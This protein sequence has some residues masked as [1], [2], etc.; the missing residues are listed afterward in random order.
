MGVAAARLVFLGF[1][2]LTGSIIY[3]ALYLQNLH[4]GAGGPSARQDMSADSADMA[5]LAPVRT[6]LPRLR[7]KPG[8][9]KLV[10]RAVQRELA[11]RGF[12][13]GPV[14]GIMSAKTRAAISSYEKAH[15]LPVTGAATDALLRQILLGD[16]VR[17]NGSTGSVAGKISP[18]KGGSALSV[19]AIQQVLADLGY[20]PGAVDGEMGEATARAISAFQRDRKIAQ[21]GKIT[22][23][24]LNELERVTGRGPGKL[25]AER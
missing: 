21:T 14:D 24:L 4:S 15:N 8:Q 2:G 1:L 25:V 19:K 3:N 12:D 20:S 22:P 7:P 13:V 10:V 9:P 6:D 16:S 11:V 17:P 5:E 23:E 18:A